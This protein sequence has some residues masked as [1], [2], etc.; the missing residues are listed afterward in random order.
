MTPEQHAELLVSLD[1]LRVAVEA[2]HGPDSTLV[3]LLVT[4]AFTT[5]MI[6]GDLLWATIIRGKNATRL[7]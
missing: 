3:F 2:T 7:W 4:I 6:Y 5:V 1:A